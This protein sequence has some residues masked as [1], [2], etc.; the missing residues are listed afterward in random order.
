[1]QNFRGGRGAI[2]RTRTGTCEDR[3]RMRRS[4]GG[5]HDQ[6]GQFVNPGP[7][8]SDQG[9]KYEI[10]SRD[11]FRNLTTDEKLVT[12]F[13]AITNIGSLGSRVQKVESR[14]TILESNN[15]SHDSV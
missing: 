8:V 11:N 7:S 9:A 10:M 13:D 12:M 15:A 6:P 4:T 1:M 3:Q 5:G 2:P 14:V